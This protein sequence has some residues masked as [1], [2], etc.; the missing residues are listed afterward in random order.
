MK[1]KRPKK[2]VKILNIVLRIS[3]VVGTILLLTL[4]KWLELLNVNIFLLF[5]DN[6]LLVKKGITIYL[7][8]I[9]YSNLM[10]M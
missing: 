4:W 7:F 10:G 9:Y 2:I 1:E 5:F 8:I 3:L 6:L